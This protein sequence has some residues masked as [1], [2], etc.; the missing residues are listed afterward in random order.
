MNGPQ[1]YRESEQLLARSLARNE[2]ELDHANAETLAAQVHATLA[3]AAATIDV[4][5]PT[6]H[7]VHN[8]WKS[9]TS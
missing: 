4:L 6:E 8:A 3:A 5:P 1:H 2:G 7:A 9:V